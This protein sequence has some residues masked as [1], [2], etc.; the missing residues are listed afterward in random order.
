M[1]VPLL[2]A[3]AEAESTSGNTALLIGGG[4]MAFFL[5]AL[6]VTAS[7]TNVGRRHEAHAEVADMHR[8]HTN[9]HGHH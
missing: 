6:L 8:Q 3:A 4:I 2:S 7:Y 1:L 5:L 9:K